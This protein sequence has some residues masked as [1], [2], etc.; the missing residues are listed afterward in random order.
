VPPESL[1]AFNRFYVCPS[2]GKVYWEGSHWRNIR[3][4]LEEARRRA[5]VL[6]DAEGR[7]G[8]R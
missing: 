1:R 2:C 6:R 4:I 5:E 8:G 7:R 3:R